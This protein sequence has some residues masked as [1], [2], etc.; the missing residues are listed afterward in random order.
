MI[1]Q[2]DGTSIG[3]I[4]S[5]DDGSIELPVTLAQDGRNLTVGVKLNGGVFVASLT[6]ANELAGTYTE[7]GIQFPLT[8]RR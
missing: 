8:F 3:T 2:P 4:I 6:D 1:N 7:S 5:V